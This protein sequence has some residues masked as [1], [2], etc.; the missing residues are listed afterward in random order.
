MVRKIVIGRLTLDAD[1]MSALLNEKEIPTTTREFNILY[2]LLSYP[3]KTFQRAQ[4]MDEFWGVDSESLQKSE[5]DEKQR[6]AVGIIIQS[7]RKLSALITNIL[8]I[9]KLEK[10]N[11]LPVMEEYDLCGQLCQ[12]SLQFEGGYGKK[13]I[14]I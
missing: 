8:K 12:C 14:G 9:N 10:Q 3:N 1:A 2:K 4:L 13:A 7:G 11:I 5:L 6:Q